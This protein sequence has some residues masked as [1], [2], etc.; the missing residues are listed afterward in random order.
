AKGMVQ[1]SHGSTY[2]GNPLAMA[3]GNAVMDVM[4]EEGFL[5]HVSAVGAR[6]MDGLGTLVKAHPKVLLGARGKGLMVGLMCAAD[7]KP[8][9]AKL[10][11]NGLLT[12]IGGGNVVRLL[13]PLITGETEI[14]EALAIIDRSCAELGTLGEGK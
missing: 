9:I 5:D 10:R 1:G 4:E 13:P 12:V 6:L 7:P 8:L 11:E 3:V 14:D 2:G